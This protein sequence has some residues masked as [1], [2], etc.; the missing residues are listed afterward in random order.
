MSVYSPATLSPNEARLSKR[1][2][3][4]EA[5]SAAGPVES[6]RRIVRRSAASED[7]GEPTR[8]RSNWN[9]SSAR[10]SSRQS[11]AEKDDGSGPPSQSACCTALC[12]LSPAR[13]FTGSA[14]KR[15]GLLTAFSRVGSSNGNRTHP[16]PELSA[17]AQRAITSQPARSARSTYVIAESIAGVL[18]QDWTLLP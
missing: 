8:N 13:E 7:H 12:C 14:C 11:W 10:M 17:P 9:P 1:R 4:S 18:H 15:S 6:R 16:H 5:G 2:S 3:I